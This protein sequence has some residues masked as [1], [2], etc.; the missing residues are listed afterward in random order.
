MLTYSQEKKKLTAK[1]WHKGEF[2]A[3][4][5]LS[6]IIFEIFKSGTGKVIFNLMI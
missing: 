1:N 6:C 3:W 2:T 4:S 5:A